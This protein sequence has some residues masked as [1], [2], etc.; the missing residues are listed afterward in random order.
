MIYLIGRIF[1][2]LR[3]GSLKLLTLAVVILL[4]WGTL[5]PVGTL[6]WWLQEGAESLGFTKKKP[7]QLLPQN[8][9]TAVAK[10]APINCYI[11]FLT[12]VGDFSADQLTPGEET[13]LNLLVQEHKNCVVVSDVFPYSV[14]NESLGGERFLAPLWR[15]ANEADGWLNVADVLIK[16]RNLWRFAISADNR[17]GPVYNRGIALAIFEQMNAANPVK[18][19]GEKPF[20]IILVGTSGGAQVALGAVPYLEQWLPK[21]Q[22][23]VVSVGGVFAGTD[24]FNAADRVYHLQGRQDWIE[25]IGSIIFPSRWSWTVGSPFNQARRQG[26]YKVYSSGPHAHDGAK[27]YFGLKLIEDNVRYVDLTVQEVEQLPIWSTQQLNQQ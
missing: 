1:H 17:Y 13:F 18:L 11:V 21:A 27:G 25:D 20:K 15:F 23:I 4:V 26:D 14:A 6:V 22:L 24:G 9:S 10:S 16:I 8:E 7:K 12:G 5:S 19:S 2:W 3:G